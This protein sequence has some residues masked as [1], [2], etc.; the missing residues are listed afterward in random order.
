MLGCVSGKVKKRD[1]AKLP[2]Y[3]REEGVT[4][5]GKLVCCFAATNYAQFWDKTPYKQSP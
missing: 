1:G 4:K 5:A 2:S 3:L